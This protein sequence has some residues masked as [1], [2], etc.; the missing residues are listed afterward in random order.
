MTGPLIP[1]GANKSK[2]WVRPS[3]PHS[4][5]RYCATCKCWWVSFVTQVSG[6]GWALCSMCHDFG[7]SDDFDLIPWDQRRIR[8][9]GIKDD[10]KYRRLHP[11]TLDIKET[12]PRTI[13]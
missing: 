6:Q 4:D 3:Q 11:L 9:L 5:A 1:A 8:L 2:A 10:P 12:A 7:W 13:H